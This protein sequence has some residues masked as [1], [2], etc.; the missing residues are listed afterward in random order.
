MNTSKHI[1]MHKLFKALAD[2]IIK[3]FIPLY[4]FKQTGNLNLAVAYLI[5]QSFFTLL[6]MSF[7]KKVLEHQTVFCVII[8][9]IP[10]ILAQSLLAFFDLSLTNILITALLMAVAQTLYSIPF[11]LIFTYC[12]KKTNVSGFQIA[13]NL[14]SLIFTLISG[15]SIAKIQGSFAYLC[16][17]SA[18]LY[19]ISAASMFCIRKELKQ[20]SFTKPEVKPKNKKT[21]LLY[22]LF[23]IGFGCFQI[24]IDYIVPLY[25]Y[26]NNLS[27]EAVTIIIALV[28]VVRILVAYF[29]KFFKPNKIYVASSLVALIS[30]II[31]CVMIMHIKNVIVLYV[32]SC[33]VEITF[34]IFFIPMYKLF[35]NQLK[36]DNFVYQGTFERDMYIFSCRPLTFASFFLCHS[37]LPCFIL[38]TGFTFLMQTSTMFIC[39]NQTKKPSD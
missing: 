15:F 25:L 5:A 13:S 21:Y 28:K 34:P 2:S 36:D 1:F 27:F 4:I 3:T 20:Y 17:I 31:S 35:C 10:I 33:L 30:F 29:V 19:I 6:T 32:L 16:L 7:L 18:I 24:I 38:G 11:N 22:N 23:H 39:K 9:C 14:G 8:H 37:F 26:A 12:D